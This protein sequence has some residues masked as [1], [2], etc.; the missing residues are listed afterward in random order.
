MLITY[1]AVKREATL[2][3]RDLDFDSAVLVFG[4]LTLDQADTRKEYGEPRFVTFGHLDERLVAIVWTPTVEGRRIISMRKAN[5]REQARF[6]LHFG[7]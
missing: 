2:V 6:R 3:E 1:D 4:G 5:S 7:P